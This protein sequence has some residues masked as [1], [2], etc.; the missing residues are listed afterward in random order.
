MTHLA[1]NRVRATYMDRLGVGRMQEGDTYISLRH[2]RIKK[3]FY[4]NYIRQSFFNKLF[5]KPDNSIELQN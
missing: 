2:K 5:N 3:A 4:E 1:R